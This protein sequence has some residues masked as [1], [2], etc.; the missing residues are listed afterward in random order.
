LLLLL[1]LFYLCL[2][3]DFQTIENN[4]FAMFVK[5]GPFLTVAMLGAG[6]CSSV[7]KAVILYL[8]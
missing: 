1:L 5:Q 8:F 3:I 2:F 6:I 4:H 7:R